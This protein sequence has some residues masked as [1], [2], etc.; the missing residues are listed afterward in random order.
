MLTSNFKFYVFLLFVILRYPFKHIFIS[1]LKILFFWWFIYIL[2]KFW[3]F[4]W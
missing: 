4:F 3:L 2:V 1:D